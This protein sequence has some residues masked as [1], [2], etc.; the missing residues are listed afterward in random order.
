[1]TCL[2]QYR[3]LVSSYGPLGFYWEMRDGVLYWRVLAYFYILCY[4]YVFFMYFVWTKIF[5]CAIVNYLV[6]SLSYL[7]VTEV[8]TLI[9]IYVMTL[10]ID[11]SFV[12]LPFCLPALKRNA[13]W[14][15]TGVTLCGAPFVCTEFVRTV[16]AKDVYLL[17]LEGAHCPFYADLAALGI[18]W[19]YVWLTCDVLSCYCPHYLTKFECQNDR[20]VML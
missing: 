1:M 11:Q 5:L 17:H 4:L 18:T 13:L 9:R 14:L 16:S 10:C 19:C 3:T 8:Q 15:I 2:F 6:G 20:L 12:A 7:L